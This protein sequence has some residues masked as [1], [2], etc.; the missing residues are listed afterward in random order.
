MI[1]N[2]R[3]GIVFFVAMITILGFSATAVACRLEQLT[4]YII[5]GE[6]MWNGV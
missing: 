1:T 6:P 2:E 4:S 5:E 3:I